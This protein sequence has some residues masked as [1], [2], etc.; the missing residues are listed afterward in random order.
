V[1]GVQCTVNITTE[2]HLSIAFVRAAEKATQ[3]FGLIGNTMGIQAYSSGDTTKR[4]GGP[5]DTMKRIQAY[6]SGDT[7]KRRGGPGDTMKRIQAYS[8]GDTT[9]RRGGPGDTMKRLQAYSSGDTTKRRGGP[10]DTMKRIQAYSSGDTIQLIIKCL[11][12]DAENTLS[13]LSR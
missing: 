3:L 7:T 9:K 10:G 2:L 13:A 11:W 4:R 1:G 6:S 8:S 5:G 12:G